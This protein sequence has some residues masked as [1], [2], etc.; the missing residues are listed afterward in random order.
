MH[1]SP[2]EHFFKPTIKTSS[3]TACL[4]CFCILCCNGYRFALTLHHRSTTCCLDLLLDT[5]G[6]GQGGGSVLVFLLFNSGDVLSFQVDKVVHA[7]ALVSSMLVC[8]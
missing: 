3:A 4:R 6:W 8:S 7:G 1:T 2:L 5:G